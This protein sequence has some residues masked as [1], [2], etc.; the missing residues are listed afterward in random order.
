MFMV[1]S[2]STKGARQ[3]NE[4]RTVF[5]ISVPAKTGKESSTRAT[6]K[7]VNLD[8]YLT[9]HIRINTK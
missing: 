8:L 2:F 3:F 1:N 9:T 7:R 4:K 5:S 6:Y